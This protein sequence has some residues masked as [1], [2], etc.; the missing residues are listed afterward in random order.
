MAIP[1]DVANIS[2]AGAVI[3][4]TWR[5][6]E[7]LRVLD[8]RQAEERELERQDRQKERE[9]SAQQHTKLAAALDAVTESLNRLCAKVDDCPT[10]RH[11]NKS[12]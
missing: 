10:H 11:N 3:I 5:F 1:P 9:L 7:Y 8:K 4:V 12:E 6:L 2:A